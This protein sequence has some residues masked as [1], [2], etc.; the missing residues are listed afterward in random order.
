MSRWRWLE[1]LLWI[2][3]GLLVASYVGLRFYSEAEARKDV[4][5]FEERL[6]KRLAEVS[7]TVT[8]PDLPETPATLPGETP[9]LPAASPA[10][11]S[12]WAP[13]RIH[14]YEE[15]LKQETSEPIAVLRIPKAGL[16]VPVFEGTDDFALNR[17][18]GWILGTAPPGKAGNCGIAGHRDGFFRPLK[19][20]VRGDSIE[21]LTLSG[22]RS[23]RIQEIQI[24][25]PT[26]VQVLAPTLEPTLTLVSCYPF[27]F[28]GTAPKRYIVRAVSTE[29]ERL[30]RK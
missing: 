14:E 24:V 6:E 3:G 2:V 20:A 4:R 1:R 21:L 8:P 16:E 29:P 26:D 13:G 5:Q 22:L 19:D 11:T 23:Y 30:S 15:S 18:V 7:P 12:L 9:T 27:Y 17:G 25:N 10:D 28:V